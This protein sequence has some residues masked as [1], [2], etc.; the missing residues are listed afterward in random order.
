MSTDPESSTS[1]RET[2]SGETSR[3]DVMRGGAALTLGAA[4]PASAVLTTKAA[5]AVAPTTFV[6]AHG[7]WSSAWAWK[8]VFPLMAARGHRLVV[9]TYTGLGERAHLANP[10]IDLDTHI[11][12]VTNALFY[13][14]LRDVTLIGHS[15]GGMVA[16]GVA[17]RARDRIVRLIYL[18][19]FVPDDGQS[20]Y[21][22]TGGADQGR[23]NAVDGWLVP[24]NP[25]PPDTSPE[26]IAWL[27]PRRRHHPIK[28]LEQPLVLTQGP[29]TLPIN[30]VLCT[31]SEAFRRFWEKAKT[32]GW[33]VHELDA[34]HSPNVTAPE[35]LAALLET[36]VA[37]A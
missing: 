26:D 36:I 21:D 2:V 14:D 19:A 7:A 9:P 3:R 25:P 13:E 6:V 28:S 27:T 22:V 8:R 4:L 34:S 35:A 33:T 15:Y 30:Y 11:T 5:A 23:A 12:D 31:K 20:F 17:D 18:D 29:L 16:T 1:H 32:A 24:P 10:D 37:A